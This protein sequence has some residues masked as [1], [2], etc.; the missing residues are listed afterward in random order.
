MGMKICITCK[1]EKP[2]TNEY[3]SNNVRK[4]DGF[5]SDCKMCAK[6]TRAN[7]SEK[8]KEYNNLNKERIKIYLLKWVE[9]HKSNGR[10]AMKKYRASNKAKET[11]SIYYQNNKDKINDYNEKN[12]GKNKEIIKENHR[13]YCEANKKHISEMNKKWRNNNRINGRIKDQKREAMKRNLPCTLTIAEWENIKLFFNNRCC[14]CNKELPLTQDYF[15]PLSKNGEYTINNIVPCCKSCNS[16]KRN[17]YFESWYP[18]YKFYSKKREKLILNF[19][20]YKDGQQQ[21]KII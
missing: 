8:T 2:K 6:V 15:I 21:L 19:L 11:A 9:N 4:K 14:Y 3:F 1:I 18:K 13:K 16:S 12:K 17:R 10:A 5:Q 20:N 7:R